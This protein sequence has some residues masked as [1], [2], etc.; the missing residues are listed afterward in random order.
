MAGVNGMKSSKATKPGDVI[1]FVPGWLGECDKRSRLYQS[2]AARLEELHTDLGGTDNLSVQQRMLTERAVFLEMQLR[3]IET[4]S[5]DGAPIDANK[6][7]F[8]VNALSGVLQRLG[9]DR[10][11]RP[12]QT[13]QEYIEGSR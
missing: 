12:S 2:L 10:V 9:L 1:K 7:G 11:A 3:S 6:Y 4:Q 8:L 5:L 13:L